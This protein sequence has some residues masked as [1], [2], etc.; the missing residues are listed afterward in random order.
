M[1]KSIALLVLLSIGLLTA[2][3]F[4]EGSHSTKG[5]RNNSKHETIAI[6]YSYEDLSPFFGSQRNE[7]KGINDVGQIVGE[8]GVGVSGQHGYLLDGSK[9]T[10]IDV[11]GSWNTKCLGINK[12][13]QIVG[14]YN[15]LQG[16][17]QGFLLDEGVFTTINFPGA[18]TPYSPYNTNAQGINQHGQIVG[19]AGFYSSGGAAGAGYGR[20]FLYDK[21]GFTPIYYPNAAIDIGGTEVT[22]INDSGKIVGN[23]IAVTKENVYIYTGPGFLL[24]KGEFSIIDFPNDENTGNTWVQGISKSGHIVGYYAYYGGLHGFM[25]YDGVYSTID[26]PGSKVTIINGV[27]KYGEI[28]GMYQDDTGQ[29]HGFFATPIRDHGRGEKKDRWHNGKLEDKDQ[30]DRG[31]REEK[32]R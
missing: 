26:Y 23:A 3:A 12:H 16:G 17:P 2:M 29:E 7:A 11:P 28:V 15:F 31:R 14:T 21:H 25:L 24:D 32:D 10:T 18:N 9:L 27:N 22:G 8:Y 6:E 30:R 4:A 1:K 19:T 5:Y 13:G 20:G